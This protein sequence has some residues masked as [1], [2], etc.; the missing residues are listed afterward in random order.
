MR[1]LFLFI[2]SFFSFTH[3]FPLFNPFTPSS[4]RASSS[5]DLVRLN[6]I[7]SVKID[8]RK[9]DQTLH[10]AG[11]HIFFLIAFTMHSFL[12]TTTNYYYLQYSLFNVVSHGI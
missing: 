7:T 1:A 6:L 4:M 9:V 2:D 11:A 8:A 12:S 5:S 10:F 3:L